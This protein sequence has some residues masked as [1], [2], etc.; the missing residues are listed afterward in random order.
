MAGN[1][2][3]G[4]FIF[5]KNSGGVSRK[6]FLGCSAGSLV[7]H[8]LVLIFFGSGLWF[9]ESHKIE[10]ESVQAKLVKLGEERDKKLLPRITQ[11]KPAPK[12]EKKDEK[13]EPKKEEKPVE[14]TKPELDG[15]ANSLKPKEEPKPAKPKKEEPPKEEKQKP[16]SLDELLAGDV[17]EKIKRDA[18]AE[19]SKEG[20]KDGVED[21]DVTDPA[22][23]LKA[24][25]YARQ[26]SKK[27]KEN[28][29]IPSII[30][31]DERKKLMTR[32]YFKITYSGDVYDIKIKASSGNSV[33]DSSVIEAVKK[34]G[35]LPLPDD[36]NLKK[37]VLKEGFECPFT[38]D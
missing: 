35:R 12:S 34:T 23:A 6:T 10:F 22:L 18:R 21:G 7:F 20:A 31:A 3:N 26:V 5:G 14:K 38:S 28:W 1:V 29:N 11:P 36:K 9:A 30:S 25:M 37:L 13:P 15:K 2:R 33:Y 8:I 16:S 19:E 32:I 27:I 24:N 4:S 17:M